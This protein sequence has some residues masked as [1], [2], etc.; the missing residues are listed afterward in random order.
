MSADMNYLHELMVEL[1]KTT[2]VGVG[3]RDETDSTRGSHETKGCKK[4]VFEHSTFLDVWHCHNC[5]FSL[6][7]Q[8]QRKGHCEDSVFLPFQTTQK[9]P[10][11]PK[12]D[13][14]RDGDPQ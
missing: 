1:S 14:E 4:H 7:D 3:D 9:G 12:T 8:E 11:K 2:N 6:A 10:S 13:P 5:G